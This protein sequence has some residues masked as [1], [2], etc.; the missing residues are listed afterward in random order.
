MIEPQTSFALEAPGGKVEVTA[1]CSKGR[2][3]KVS[4]TPQPAYV[5]VSNAQVITVL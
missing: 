3:T 2:V 4:L 5:A 1:H